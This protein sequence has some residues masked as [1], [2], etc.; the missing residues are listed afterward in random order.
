MNEPL[1]YYRVHEGVQISKSSNKA[2]IG[3]SVILRK[4]ADEYK[5]YPEAKARLLLKMAK[6]KKIWGT[7]SDSGAGYKS[8]YYITRVYLQKNSKKRD[9]LNEDEDENCTFNAR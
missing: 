3:L 1:Y 9:L 5:G 7:T 6:R 8:S 4:Y 2:Y